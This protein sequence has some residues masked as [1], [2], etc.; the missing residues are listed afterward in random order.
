LS[1]AQ[2][3]ENQ[4]L[5]AENFQKSY[6]SKIDKF[7][8]DIS[9]YSSNNQNLLSSVSTRIE[10]IQEIQ[11][12]YNDL[13]SDLLSY[14]STLAGSGVTFFSKLNLL[15]QAST[16]GLDI[17]LQNIINSQVRRYRILPALSSELLEQ[18]YYA[19]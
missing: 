18:K 17:S 5:L 3:S 16:S 12:K 8:L 10:T 13:I 14:Q 9:D 19:L 1:L 11:E 7:V 6:L 4:K 15:K 2:L